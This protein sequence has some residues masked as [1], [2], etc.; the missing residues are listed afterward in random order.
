M[1]QVDLHPEDLFDGLREGTLAREAHARLLSHCA[2]CEPCQ[3][4]LRLIEGQQFA[5]DET[6]QA[7][8][9]ADAAMRQLSWPPPA[10]AL[11]R[12]RRVLGLRQ[13]LAAAAALLVLGVGFGAAA[14]FTGLP[15]AV[16]ALL[17]REPRTPTLRHVTSGTP[18]RS[19]VQAASAEPT[20]PAP[21]EI[22][23]QAP[24]LDLDVT[25]PAA[26]L[27]PSAATSPDQTTT[28]TLDTSPRASTRGAK[29]VRTP[30]TRT[31]RKAVV[32][33]L[34]AAASGHTTRAF[35]EADA[36]TALSLAT[37]ARSTGYEGEAVERYR[38][39][40]ERFA[41]TRAAGAAQVALGRLLYTEL[42]QPGAALPLFE[43]YLARRGARELTEEA[44]YHRGMC[45]IAL[46]R[47]A[48]ASASFGQ[49]LELFPSSMYAAQARAQL[50]RLRKP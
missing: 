20:S 27:P 38:M 1:T 15:R 9:L 5:L 11:P 37:Q 21:A 17:G 10:P 24:A 35:S 48:D 32:A 14:L 42:A 47:D 6:T 31:R 41:S 16:D 23:E 2:H 34:T 19:A 39:V 12:V 33:P 3:F 46:H 49:L 28:D 13:Q 36:E 50:S 4:E 30:G 45:L 43:A 25:T 7:A 29:R 8:Q 22:P 44:M 18:P 40:I 26:E